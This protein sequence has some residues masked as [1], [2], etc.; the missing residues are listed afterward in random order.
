M[1]SPFRK[2]IRIAVIII[3]LLLLFNFFGYYF[4]RL[5]SE[6]NEHLLQV[7]NIAARQRALG[8]AVTKDAMML[9]R[10]KLAPSDEQLIRINLHDALSSFQKNNQFLQ[11]Q[12]SLPGIPAPPN[13]A[14]IKSILS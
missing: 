5:R 8:D 12:I 1:S 4:L 3:S 10:G 14:N 6:E 7:V 2:L 13:N 9:G 11:Q